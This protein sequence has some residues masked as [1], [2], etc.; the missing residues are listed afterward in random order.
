[1]T[2]KHL[3]LSIAILGTFGLS[4]PAHAASSYWSPAPYRLWLTTLLGDMEYDSTEFYQAND[5]ECSRTWADSCNVWIAETSGEVDDVRAIEGYVYWNNRYIV[6]F[7]VHYYD[8]GPWMCSG[9]GCD[10]GQW[11]D[12]VDWLYDAWTA[13]GFYG[14]GEWSAMSDRGPFDYD[15]ATP[16]VRVDFELEYAAGG[17]VYE[18]TQAIEIW[19]ETTD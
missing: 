12:D 17:Y 15:E 13:S 9:K 1:M 19:T 2:P 5:E 7:E 11:S 8:L 3:S 10:A 16:I 6:D 14:W 18:W 4:V